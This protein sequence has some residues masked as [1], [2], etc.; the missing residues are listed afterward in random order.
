VEKSEWSLFV[1]RIVLEKKLEWESDVAP[2]PTILDPSV[3]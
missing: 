3:M 1:S 2:A